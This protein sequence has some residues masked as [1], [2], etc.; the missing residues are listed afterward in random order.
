MKIIR[1]RQRPFLVV[2]DVFFTVLAWIGLLYLLVRG[3]LPLVGSH[4]GGPRI[5]VSLLDALSTLEIYLWIA[6]VNAA[7][8]VGWARYRQLR[9][10]RYP[11][12]LPAPVVDDQRLSET[13][14]L[15]EDNFT[16]IRLPGTMVV[17]NDE[18]GGISHV[19]TQFYR[20]DPQDQLHPPLAAVTPPRVI[21]LP[22]EDAKDTDKR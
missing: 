19:A 21:H 5:D 11:P 6:L 3:L 7:L 14:K 20:I 2:V 1:T 12:R 9:S 17:H 4:E 16:R 18:E 10:R 13:F 22:D 8:L 15:S